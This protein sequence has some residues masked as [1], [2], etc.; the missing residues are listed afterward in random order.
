MQVQDVR[1]MILRQI[2]NQMALSTMKTSSFDQE[3]MMS[4]MFSSSSVQDQE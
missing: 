4:L 1:I 3:T 2:T